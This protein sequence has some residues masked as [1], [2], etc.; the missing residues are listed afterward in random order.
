MMQSSQ[1]PRRSRQSTALLSALMAQASEWR[2][3]LALARATGLKSGTLYP[4]LIRLADQGFLEARWEAPE[5]EGR[6]ARHLYRLTAS[7]RE[8]ARERTC[9][10]TMELAPRAVPA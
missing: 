1:K 2:H 3:G 9:E 4:M 6:P 10:T 5:V 7:G 8:L